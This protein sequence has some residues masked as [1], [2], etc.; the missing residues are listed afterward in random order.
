MHVCSVSCIGVSCH[1]FCIWPHRRMLS[2]G[3]A[4]MF[5]MHACVLDSCCAAACGL[6]LLQIVAPRCCCGA[7]PAPGCRW[8]M[9]PAG[10][11]VHLWTPTWQ[12][13]HCPY[14][15]AWPRDTWSCTG[16]SRRCVWQGVLVLCVRVLFWVLSL[17][18]SLLGCAACVR[19]RSVCSAGGQ[20]ACLHP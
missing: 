12:T 11:P 9:Q 19:A 6:L 7:S 18:K 2:A 20:V 14:G 17:F 8:C 1:T 10:G 3:S 16:K 15:S 4:E 5:C 13:R